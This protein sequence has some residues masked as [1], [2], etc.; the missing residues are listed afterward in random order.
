MRRT[1]LSSEREREMS[2]VGGKN[3]KKER[4]FER[5]ERHEEHQSPIDIS[6]LIH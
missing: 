4:Y 6:K 2:R 3:E 5:R 1:E